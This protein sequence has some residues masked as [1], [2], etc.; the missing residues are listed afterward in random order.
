MFVLLVLEVKFLQVL[1]LN[2]KLVLKLVSLIVPLVLLTT[3]V[4]LVVVV[5]LFP[6]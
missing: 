4:L 2:V 1:V 3:N 5:K 6:P